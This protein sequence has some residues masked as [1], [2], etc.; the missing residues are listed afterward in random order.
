MGVCM[1]KPEICTRE[2]RPTCG[3]D[4]ATYGNP[5]LANANGA[6]VK[7]DGACEDDGPQ[8]C[9]GFAGTP[10][11]GAQYCHYEAEARCGIADATGVCLDRP[12]VCT[13]EFAP[14]CGCDGATHGNACTANANGT[15]VAARGAC[16]EDPPDGCGGIAGLTCE[17]PEDTIYCHYEPEQSCGAGDQM[18]ACRTRPEICTRQFDPVCGCDGLTHGNACDANARGVSVRSRG[19]CED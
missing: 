3:C 9:G 6:S 13:R 5:C 10:C 12:E 15:S 7:S 4:G 11:E 16:D 17:G 1:T 14:V 19:A 18:G 8:V 2:F